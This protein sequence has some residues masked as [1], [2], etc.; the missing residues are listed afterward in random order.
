V[1]GSLAPTTPTPSAREITSPAPTGPAGDVGRA[2]PLFEQTLA[3]SDRVLGPDH[4]D[5]W[6]SRVYLADAYVSAGDLGRAIPL[7]E[8]TLAMSGFLARIIPTS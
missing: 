6:G 4:L 8:Q 7:L 2:L 1:S 3:D 5:T